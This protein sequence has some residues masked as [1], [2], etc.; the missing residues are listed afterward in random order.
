[1][2]VHVQPVPDLHAI[3]VDR[4]GFA[5][6]GV[7]N[8]ERDQFFG[9]L[10]RAVVVG[11]VADADRQPVGDV[12]SPHEVVAGGFGGGIG[13]A[14]LVGG[15]LLKRRLFTRQRAKDLIGGNMVK[16]GLLHRHGLIHQPGFARG[17]QQRE[18]AQHIG[19]HEHARVMDG[20]VHVRFGGKMHHRVDCVFRKNPV[21]QGAVGNVA[22]DK[23][24]AR[25][26]GQV[27]QVF[28]AAGI[29]ERVQGHNPDLGICA[30]QVMHKIRTYK[31]GP[32]SH[33]HIMRHQPS[34][35]SSTVQL[36]GKV[37]ASVRP[38]LCSSLAESSGAAPSS[39]GHWMPIAGSSHCKPR[40]HSGA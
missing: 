1:M 6:A 15:A 16:A 40:S 37:S 33:Q 19:L 29:G 39:S 23:A 14:R 38:G 24:V 30:Q 17:F 4:Q 9:E 8:H 25:W 36:A 18:G 13:R 21:Q 35:V 26:V 5:G 31:A 2:V 32:T 7:Q 10:T 27:F 11:A 22:L 3:A 34:L 28:Q 12:I 20:A